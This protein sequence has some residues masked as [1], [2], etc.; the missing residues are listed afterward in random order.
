[1]TL[2]GAPFRRSGWDS[3]LNRNIPRSL[4]SSRSRAFATFQPVME[5]MKYNRELF[6][7][8]S[9][10]WMYVPIHIL[11]TVSLIDSSLTLQL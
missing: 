11:S 10:R 8:T 5:D 9:G 6:E 7:Y 2:H 3:F 1:M 4:S